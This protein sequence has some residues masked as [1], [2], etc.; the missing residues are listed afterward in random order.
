[1]KSDFNQFSSKRNR[2]SGDTDAFALSCF[3]NVLSAD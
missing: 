3:T 1:M 2:Y